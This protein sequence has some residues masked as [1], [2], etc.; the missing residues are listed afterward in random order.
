[1]SDCLGDAWYGRREEE[2]KEGW[3]RLMAL[4]ARIGIAAETTSRARKEQLK[5]MALSIAAHA[6]QGGNKTKE[7]SHTEPK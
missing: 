7:S 4:M 3:P 6:A 5:A 2:E 1:M